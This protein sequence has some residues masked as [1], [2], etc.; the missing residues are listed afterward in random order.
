MSSSQV[1]GGCRFRVCGLQGSLRAIVGAYVSDYRPRD[2]VRFHRRQPSLERALEVVASWQDK[3]GKVYS[4]QCLVPRRAKARAGAA[5]R[6][7]DLAGVAD[8]EDLFPRV[9]DAIGGIRGVGPLTVYDVATRIGAFIRC[10]PRRRVYLHSGA[11][12][13]ARA[14]GLPT[15]GRSLPVQ[16]FPRELRRL[17]AWEIEDVLCIYSAELARLRKAPS[18]KA[19]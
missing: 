7:L 13:G 19:A 8:F 2:W 11:R 12:A 18:A 9:Q 4:H 16:A 1:E 10:M 14:L 3:R 6:A 17:R 15:H 5:I